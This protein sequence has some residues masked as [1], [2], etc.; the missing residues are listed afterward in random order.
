MAPSDPAALDRPWRVWAS[1]AIV[2][3][4]LFSVVFGFIVIPVVQGYA[5]GIDPYTA[6]CRAIGLAPGAPPMPQPQSQAQAQPTTLVSWSPDLLRQLS[7]PSPIA[8]ETAQQCAACHGEQGVAPDPQFPNLAGQSAVAIY[9][10]LHDYKSGSRVHDVMTGVAQGL[11]D[12][13][14]VNLAAHFAASVKKDIDPTRAPYIDALVVRLVE[15]GDPARGLP[16]CNSCHGATAGGPIETP[17]LSRQ[18]ADYLAA[19]LRAFR[20]GERRNDIYTRM[21][22][23][24]V[25]LTDREIDALAAFYAATTVY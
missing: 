20:G 15:R 24:A 10:Q 3:V 1:V 11:E 25:K 12:Q 22:S 13:D 14:I 5:G 16:A 7:R 4:L 23:I 21:R 17:T 9:K 6:I 18:S 19:Q 2:G 8:A